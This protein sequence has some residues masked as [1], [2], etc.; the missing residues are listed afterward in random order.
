MH[1]TEGETIESVRRERDDLSRTVAAMAGALADIA[2]S[3]DEF[4]EPSTAAWMSARAREVLSRRDVAA[5]RARWVSV[6]TKEKMR[7]TWLARINDLNLNEKLVIIAERD[8]AIARAEKAE[9]WIEDYKAD[10]RAVVGGQCAG[11]ERHCSCVPHLRNELNELGI[12]L[13]ALRERMRLAMAVVDAA[14]WVG[15]PMVHLEQAIDA[16]D[17]VPGDEK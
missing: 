13:E 14:R 2:D 3:E 15:R 11:D 6:E 12:Q 1:D 8:A 4:G 10:H 5:E 17:T 16:F 9:C 7:Q